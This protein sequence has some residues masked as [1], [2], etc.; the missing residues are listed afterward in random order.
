MEQHKFSF[1]PED[2]LLLV[3]AL[4]EYAE[5]TLP[6]IT[7]HV[8]DTRGIIEAQRTRAMILRSRFNGML[9]A[10]A[11]EQAKAQAEAAKPQQEPAPV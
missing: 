7:R 9:R 3:D 5:G 8:P 1:G 10:H 6:A 4:T 11:A 2:L